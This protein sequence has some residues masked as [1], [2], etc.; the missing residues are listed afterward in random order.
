MDDEHWQRAVINGQNYRVSE[1]E[2]CGVAG[3]TTY[4][5]HIAYKS[6]KLFGRY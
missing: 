1:W 5:K 2:S 6:R 4:G 3:S